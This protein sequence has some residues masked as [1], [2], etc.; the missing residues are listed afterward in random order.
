V[1]RDGEHGKQRIAPT[2][3]RVFMTPAQPKVATTSPSKQRPKQ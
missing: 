2:A 3:I 1:L